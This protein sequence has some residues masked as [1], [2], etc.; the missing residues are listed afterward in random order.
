LQQRR[1]W[2]QGRRRHRRRE[3]AEGDDVRDG[4]RAARAEHEKMALLRVQPGDQIRFVAVP[5]A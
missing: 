1:A 3:R 2:H 4:L 5:A